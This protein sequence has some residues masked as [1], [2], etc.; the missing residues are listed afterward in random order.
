MM[1]RSEIARELGHPEAQKLLAGAMARLAY[2]GHDGF[3]R[4]IPVGF[5]WTG[6]CVVVS[7]A[8]TSP[9]AKALASRPQVAPRQNKR[10]LC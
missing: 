1:D 8:P 2:N 3:P 5:H 9:K 7:T 10:R 6:E 4:V